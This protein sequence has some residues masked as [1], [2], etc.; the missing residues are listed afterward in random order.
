MFEAMTGIRVP[1]VSATAVWGCGDNTVQISVGVCTE[2]GKGKHPMTATRVA[3]VVR[4]A[5]DLEMLAAAQ[6]RFV[7]RLIM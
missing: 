5:T 1:L 3:T 7:V 4:K 6:F 2:R